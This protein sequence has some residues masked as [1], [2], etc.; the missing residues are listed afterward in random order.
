MILTNIKEKLFTHEDSYHLH[1]SLGLYCLLNYGYQFYLYFTYKEPILNFFTILPHILLHI[2]SFNFK[3]L[4]KR[5]VESRMAMFIWKE[6]R[7]H[8][9]IF[10]WRACFAILFVNYCYLFTFLAMMGADV[11]TFIYGTEGVSSIRGQHSKVGKR[12]TIKEFF[13]TFFSISQF[14]AII[15]TLG[16]FQDK[17]SKILIFSTLPP[18]QTSSFGMTLIRKNMITYK[19]WSTLYTLE[20]LFTFL[21]WYKE[22]NN[23][24]VLPLSMIVYF[25]RCNG[26]SKYTI[27][28]YL[29]SINYFF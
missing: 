10:A 24:C 16:I 4:E 1:K 17:P 11:A 13:T 7:L 29:C 9:L 3:V 23:L 25:L 22:N 19:T 5:P 28:S 27:W 20:L 18:I 21:I 8:S 26:I 15:I 12:D 2:S 6:Q 14:G